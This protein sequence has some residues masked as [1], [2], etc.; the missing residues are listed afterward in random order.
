MIAAEYEISDYGKRLKKLGN[1]VFTLSGDGNWVEDVIS[2]LPD[3]LFLLNMFA[4]SDSNNLIVAWKPTDFHVKLLLY[5]GHM[6][7]MKDGP[8]HAIRNDSHILIC[9]QTVFLTN[10]EECPLFYKTSLEELQSVNTPKWIDVQNIPRD[11]SNLI[12]FCGRLTL[13]FKLSSSSVCAV[14]YL[15]TTD[16]WIELGDLRVNGK[17]QGLPSLVGVSDTRLI[18]IG[19]TTT[20]SDNLSP[21]AEYFPTQYLL[22]RYPIASVPQ[23]QGEK[24][25]ALVVETEGMLPYPVSI[26]Y[27][28]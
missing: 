15:L 6:W 5:D 4:C 11:H 21:M 16:T 22:G 14:Q 20:E 9:E 13:V 27:F 8:D 25:G 12:S 1:K 17:F 10:C 26:P 24:F 2:P 3:D 7:K 28:S 18:L 19:Q 23:Q